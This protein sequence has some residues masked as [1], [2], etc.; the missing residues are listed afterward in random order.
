MVDEYNSKDVS[1]IMERQN[2]NRR[3]FK[4]YDIKL[5]EYIN[6]TKK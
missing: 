2:Y 5:T 4:A 6:K 1:K 3:S